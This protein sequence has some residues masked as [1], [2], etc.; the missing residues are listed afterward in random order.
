M[1]NFPFHQAYGFPD[2]FR[3]EVVEFSYLNGVT[4]SAEAYNV[5]RVSVWRWRQA[6]KESNK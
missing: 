3:A 1:T 2:E 4:A 5:S 6:A